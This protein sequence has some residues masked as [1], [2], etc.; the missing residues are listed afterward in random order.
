MLLEHFKRIQIAE[1]RGLVCGHGIDH[2]AMQPVVGMGAQGTDEFID[3]REILRA[4][5]AEKARFDEIFLARLEDNR[6]LL[7]HEVTHVI[8]ICGCHD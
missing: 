3:G 6:G 8:E 4:R 7:A 2:L 5:E 1:E